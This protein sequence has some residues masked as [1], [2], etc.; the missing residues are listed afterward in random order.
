METIENIKTD[1]G[2]RAEPYI[3]PAGK[4][5]VLY[6]R[7]IEDRPFTSD[8]LTSLKEILKAGGTLKDWADKL[9]EEEIQRL[10]DESFY[11][12]GF[13]R[14]GAPEEVQNI[15]LNMAYNMGLTRFS[16]ARWP[17]FFAAVAAQDY[18]EAA[19][20]MIDSRWYGQVGHRA[21]RLVNS[22]QGV[23]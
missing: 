1:E 6:G 14:M 12:K 17:K 21:T 4:L 10:R 8:E 13:A 20:Q 2:Y 22:M 15:I 23:S 16:P 9:F 3:C 11:I 19:R 7:N 5:T 18:Q